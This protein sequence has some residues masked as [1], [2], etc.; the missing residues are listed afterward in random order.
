M[1]GEAGPNKI[2]FQMLV[3]LLYFS[4]ADFE[5]MKQNRS[6]RYT[7]FFCQ[8]HTAFEGTEAHQFV[9]AHI[10]NKTDIVSSL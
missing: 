10:Q 4:F 2:S 8:I 6:F 7:T 3:N 1:L 5:R 9:A